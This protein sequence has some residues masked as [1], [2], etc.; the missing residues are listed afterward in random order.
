MAKSPARMC[1]LLAIRPVRISQFPLVRRVVRRHSL[2][3]NQ[4]TTVLCH[5]EGVC[6]HVLS[7]GNSRGDDSEIQPLKPKRSENPLAFQ[8]QQ[9]PWLGKMAPRIP[10]LF[11]FERK[12][13]IGRKL[14]GNNLFLQLG[15]PAVWSAISEEPRNNPFIASWSNEMANSRSSASSI[16]QPRLCSIQSRWES[17]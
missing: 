17:R 11:H 9:F 4:S 3:P 7:E 5:C 16:R 6:W 8:L 10:H 1:N 15:H 2:S 13:E 14:D 12:D